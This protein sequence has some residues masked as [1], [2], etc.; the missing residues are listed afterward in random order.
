[1]T[2]DWEQKVP[3]AGTFT[4]VQSWSGHAGL[5]QAAAV[6]DKALWLLPNGL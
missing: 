5:S 3:A 6:A 1:M 2:K 4:R